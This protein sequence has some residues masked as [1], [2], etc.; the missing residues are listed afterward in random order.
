M[1]RLILFRHAKTEN[2]AVDGEDID[3]VLTARGR[4]DAERM[5]R[6]LAEAGITPDLVLISPAVRT[7]ETWELVSPALPGARV[8]VREGLYDATPEEVD[9]ELRVGTAEAGTVMVVGHNPSLHE[10]AMELLAD[11]HS[12]P[13]DLERVS[14]G[15]PTATA[16]IFAFDAEMRANLQGLFHARG[17]GGE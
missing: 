16:A 5:G 13:A 2:R 7:R 10:L 3:R 6:I 11:G 1:Q 12:L 14:V 9:A 17:H 8:E 4:G 15:F